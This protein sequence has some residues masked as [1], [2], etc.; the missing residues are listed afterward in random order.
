MGDEGMLAEAVDPLGA[1]PGDTVRIRTTGVEGKIKA[2][3]L[4]FGLPLAMLLLGAGVTDRLL[5]G[6]RLGAAVEALSVLAGLALVAASFAVLY[7][8]RKR[9]GKNAVQSRVVEILE[10]AAAG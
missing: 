3:L 1:R 6:S 5:R 9:R 4:L 2:A 8:V 7:L 10:R